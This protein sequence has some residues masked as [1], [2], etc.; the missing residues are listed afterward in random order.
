MTR[1]AEPT[2][3]LL[4]ACRRG[5]R[6]AFHD[7]FVA[8]R[9]RV[10]SIALHYFSGDP[11]TARDV[12]QD[13]Y[14]KLFDRIDQY[15]GTSRFTTWLHRVVVNTCLDEKRRRRRDVGMD[16]KSAEVLALVD[17][18]HEREAQSRPLVRDIQAAVGRLAPPLR[19][20]LLLRYFEDLSYD[21]MAEAL[22]CTRG[23]VASR[24]NRAH[25]LL[26]QSLGRKGY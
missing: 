5:D 19:S 1:P 10:Y 26:A 21:E 8:T 9:D 14:V 24:L 22:G 16:E 17:R 2:P 20:A 12:T 18:S 6:D 7:L 4:E 23:T 11:A 25:R 13:V 15:R 3:E